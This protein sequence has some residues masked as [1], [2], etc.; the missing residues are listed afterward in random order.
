MK[1]KKNQIGLLFVLASLCFSCK[2]SQSG[3]EALTVE[4]LKPVDFPKIETKELSAE[5]TG[6]RITDPKTKKE[7]DIYLV[8]LQKQYEI[9]PL[10]VVKENDTEVIYPGSII[11]GDSFMEGIYK[12]LELKN[13][14]E[15]LT[16]SLWLRGEVSTS[17]RIKPISRLVRPAINDL[18]S[19]KKS[20]ANYEFLPSVWWDEGYEISSQESMKPALNIHAPAAMLGRMAKIDFEYEQPKNTSSKGKYIMLSFYQVLY[21]ASIKDPKHYSQWILGDIDVKDWGA[22][23]ALYI[24][25]VG[26]GRRGYMLIETPKSVSEAQRMLEAAISVAVKYSTRAEDKQYSQEMQQLFQNNKIKMKIYGGPAELANEVTNYEGFEKF[27]QMPTAE[28]L[29]KTSVPVSYTVRRLKDNSLVKV[30]DTYTESY[31]EVRD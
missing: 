27:I 8:I 28:T 23:E 25:E 29:T 12:P 20:E 9:N 14:F 26:Y 13:E 21:R 16:L 30:L 15:W 1:T 18:L 22:Y 7:R 24:S 11:R 6:N 2:P 31:Y 5:K 19:Q 17:G 3:G 4:T 10:A